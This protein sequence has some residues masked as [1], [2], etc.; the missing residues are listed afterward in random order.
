MRIASLLATLLFSAPLFA[1]SGPMR[2][3]M[4][5]QAIDMHMQQS[6]TLQQRE[7]ME[8][9]KADPQAAPQTAPKTAVTKKSKKKAAK[10]AVTG[11]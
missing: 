7:A 9:Q 2:P 8:A 1:Q 11:R 6:R 3:P 4:L 5:P 10:P